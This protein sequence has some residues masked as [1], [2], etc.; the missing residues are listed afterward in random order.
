[1]PCASSSSTD[2]IASLLCSRSSP[3]FRPACIHPSISRAHLCAA[4]DCLGSFSAP[5]SSDDAAW[6]ELAFSHIQEKIRLH[7]EIG[8]EGGGGFGGEI[9]FNLLALVRDRRIVL[10]EQLSSA[11]SDA[12][13]AEINAELV[14]E[15]KRHE[16]WR[17]ENERRRHN[18][19]PFIF[20]LLK[21]CTRECFLKE[22]S[23][24]ATTYFRI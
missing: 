9:R 22:C 3:S 23:T 4:P 5:S 20:T 19:I 15:E 7:S 11:S 6:L 2:A 24:C 12:Q 8:A 1:M 13:R 21:V 16:A 17:L 10:R 18:Y 14:L